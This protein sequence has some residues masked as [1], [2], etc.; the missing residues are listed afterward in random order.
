MNRKPFFSI[1]IN[2]HN[3]ER[4]LREAVDSIINQSFK[5]FEIIIYDNNSSDNTR[6]IAASYGDN[7]IYQMSNVKLSLGAARNKAVDKAKGKYLAFLDSDDV[8]VPGKLKSQYDALTSF[9]ET[10]IGLCG[11]DAMRVS[12]DLTPIAKYSLGRFPRKSN[13]VDSLIHDCFIPMSSTVVNRAVCIELGGFDENFEI[14]EEWDLWIR[15]A[16]DYDVIYLNDC[17][18]NIRFHSSNTSR[19]YRMQKT[20]IL[21]MFSNIKKNN[22]V[23]AATLS[24]ARA[25]WELRWKIV[26]LFNFEHGSL[27]QKLEMLSDLILFLLKRPSILFPVIRS[28]TNVQLIKFALVKYTTKSEKL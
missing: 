7:I 3:A 24:S 11:S 12:S 5:N 22:K 16:C 14:I 23:S 15:I 26:H 10:K 25:S 6:C 13:M 19:D 20:E 4:Y 2:C 1:I 8:W 27:K 9:S 17:L 18:V 21:K 28:Y